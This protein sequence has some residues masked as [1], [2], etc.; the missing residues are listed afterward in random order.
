MLEAILTD[1][2]M[3]VYQ[4]AK[5]S[6]IPYT[7]LLE[8]VRGKTQLGKCSAETVYRLSKA[9]DIS[10]EEL[11]ADSLVHRSDFEVFKSNV[12]HA[13]KDNGDLD[14]II[15]TLKSDE[16]RQYWTRKWYPEAFYLLAMV[17]Y[18]SRINEIPLCNKYDDIRARSLSRTIYPKDVL[19]TAKLSPE[20]DVRESS[21]KESIPEFMRFNIVESDV[22]NVY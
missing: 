15:S 13:V 1:K 4:C 18:L 5:R 19:M 6:G 8:V 14:F 20:L 17:D 3:S 9:L 11:I 22:R 10:M 16:I 21:K 12:C 2:N 7:T